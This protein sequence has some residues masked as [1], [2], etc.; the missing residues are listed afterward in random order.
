M[1]E[2]MLALIRPAATYRPRRRKAVRGG[3]VW[4]ASDASA[5]GG[6][7]GVRRGSDGSK[8]LGLS[9]SGC[10]GRLVCMFFKFFSEEATADHA[11]FHG[12]ARTVHKAEGPI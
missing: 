3:G 11:D 6:Q 9:G 8:W 2:R 4:D 1:G 5:D 7:T 10:F 12:P